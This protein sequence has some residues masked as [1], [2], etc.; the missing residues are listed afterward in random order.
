MSRHG[1]KNDHYPLKLGKNTYGK[2]VIMQ[3]H[4]GSQ[5]IAN[6]KTSMEKKGESRVENLENLGW[7]EHFV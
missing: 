7:V 6:N 3:Y 1:Q 4:K 2:K 5:N